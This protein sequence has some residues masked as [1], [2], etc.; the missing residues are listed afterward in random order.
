MPP[1]PGTRTAGWLAIACI[2]FVI[3]INGKPEFTNASKPPRGF[4]N[5]GIA[6]QLIRNTTEVD[7]ILGDAPSP[8]REAIRI[9]QYI[10]FGFIAC[11]AALFITLG[12]MFGTALA[13]TAAGLGCLAAVFD[14]LENIGIL[15]IV[16]VP[17]QQV[18]QAMI[19][20]VRF[21]SLAKW[22]LSWITLAMFSIL[23]WRCE[24]RLRKSIAI[25]FGLAA[26]IGFYGLLDNPAIEIASI[27]LG[28][29]LVVLGAGFVYESLLRP[30]RS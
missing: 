26:A 3:L 30:K 4:H 19:D 27:P 23:F 2:V 1:S 6:M 12:R 17:T 18:T 16:D 14:V 29:G 22:T 20:S 8:D 15:R 5:P 28:L 7:A 10:D 21:P 13:K 11:Y 25:L 24:G 9:K